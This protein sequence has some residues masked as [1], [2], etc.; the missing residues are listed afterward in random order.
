LPYH[1]RNREPGTLSIT[2]ARC[3]VH[4]KSCSYICTYLCGMLFFL[5]LVWLFCSCLETGFYFSH[6]PLL[7]S[8]FGTISGVVHQSHLTQRCSMVLGIFVRYPNPCPWSHGGFC[9]CMQ[10]V[11]EVAYSGT[12]VSGRYFSA[13][14]GW[15]GFLDL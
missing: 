8:E 14:D 5:V 2:I 1:W 10:E 6:S 9:R 3:I 11:F 7:D 4:F 15:D 12:N 13:N